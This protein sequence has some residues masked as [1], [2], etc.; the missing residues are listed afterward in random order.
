MTNSTGTSDRLFAKLKRGYPVIKQPR[1][2]LKVG[3]GI[4]GD[5]NAHAFSP[6]Q[7]LIV[8]QEDLSE[9]SIKAGEFRENIA[10]AL[11]VV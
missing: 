7:I 8:R 10:I 9:L 2:I 3:H 11:M 1:L 5:I 4:E 6:R